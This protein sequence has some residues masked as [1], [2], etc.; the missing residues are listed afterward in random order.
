[1]LL[2][3]RKEEEGQTMLFLSKICFSMYL[4]GEEQE[5]EEVD[6]NEAFQAFSLESWPNHIDTLNLRGQML[7][8]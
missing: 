4:V 2:P 3:L 1:M 5:R 7:Q 8:T 6:Q